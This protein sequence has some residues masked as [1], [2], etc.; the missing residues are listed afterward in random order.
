MNHWQETLKG[1]IFDMDGTL[2]NTLD[3]IVDSINDTL[4]AWSLPR[5]TTAQLLPFIGYGA[6]HLCRGATGLED[7]A[8]IELFHSQY[9]QR[10]LTR[11]DTKTEPYA[12]IEVVVYGLK[13]RGIK[14]GIYTN[15]PQA[16]TEKL[17]ARYFRAKTFDAI[18]G[19]TEGGYLKPS[20]GGIFDMCRLWQIHPSEVVM[21]GDSPVDIETAHNAGCG[22][23]AC[24]WGFRPREA[25]DSIGADALVDDAAS[26]N[27]LL[28]R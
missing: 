22:G 13:S 3:D 28:N 2:L 4:E 21:V 20:P 12:G 1:V 9:R 5:K 25:L 18:V 7:A 6:K 11:E 17:A 19:V 27:T 23:I 15:K 8:Q 26:L 24:T 16:W 10:T 14:V